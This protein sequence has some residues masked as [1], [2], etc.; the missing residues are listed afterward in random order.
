MNN[1]VSVVLPCMFSDMWTPALADFC[2]TTM[3][4]QTS[5]RFEL[6]VVETESR[7]LE[8]HGEID[9]YLHRDKKTSYTK[10]FNVGTGS[11]TGDFIVHTGIDVIVGNRWLESMIAC[12]EK[13]DCGVSSTGIKESGDVFGPGVPQV[14]IVE[15]FYGA[16]MM[17]PKE[18]QLDESFPD[19]FSDYDL[20]MQVYDKG[21]RAYRN[22]VS[23]AH[24]LKLE[25]GIGKV[26]NDQRFLQGFQKFTKK[27]SDK[28]WLI[29]NLILKGSVKYGEE[30]A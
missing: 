4:M 19:Q 22:N 18:F 2:I 7:L 23:I 24:H 9:V 8:S 1:Q 28:H 20:C 12:F 6:V 11:A 29:K 21:L 16:L 5:N 30:H 25:H 13:D 15:S 3:R 26:Q 14:Q 10:D 17:F 27:W